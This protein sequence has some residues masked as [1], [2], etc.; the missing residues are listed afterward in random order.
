MLHFNFNSF[1]KEFI[2]RIYSFIE[3]LFPQ[4]PVTLRSGQLIAA[5]V[6]KYRNE[7]VIK[8][9]TKI[10]PWL[11]KQQHILITL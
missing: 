3:V 1:R 11:F 10:F 2:I 4:M 8:F 7:Y 9:L 6:V 5:N